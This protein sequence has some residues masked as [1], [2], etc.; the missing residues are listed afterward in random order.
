[1][2]RSVFNQDDCT[3]FDLFCGCQSVKCCRAKHGALRV[4]L[5]PRFEILFAIT[6]RS[7]SG[8]S[9]GWELAARHALPKELVEGVTE[10][11]LGLRLGVCACQGRLLP[12]PAN[13][14]AVPPGAAKI[15]PASK[16]L[17]ACAVLISIP[18]EPEITPKFEQVCSTP[19]FR[20][21]RRTARLAMC[22]LVTGSAVNPLLIGS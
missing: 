3:I 16:M 12:L 17:T 10:R 7:P 9:H 2:R 13:W 15:A 11:S 8:A 1:M 6:A 4:N 22:H 20:Y 21:D 5:D 14:I 18:A 19:S